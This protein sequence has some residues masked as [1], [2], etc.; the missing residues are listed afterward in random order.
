MLLEGSRGFIGELLCDLRGLLV[1]LE[2]QKKSR[3]PPNKTPS[4]DA[5]RFFRD[6]LTQ[7]IVFS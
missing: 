3:K 6:I 1:A 5:P 7:Y 4:F 2:G